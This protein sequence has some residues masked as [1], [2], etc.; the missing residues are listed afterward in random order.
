[1]VYWQQF[2]RYT[3]QLDMSFRDYLKKLDESGRLLHVTT[4]I[5]KTYEIAGVLKKAEPEPVIFEKVKE[6]DFR[7]VGNLFGSKASFA[8][9]FGIPVSKI[10]S[11]LTEAISHPSPCQIVSE[12]PCQE[13]VQTEPD[14]DLLPI[15]RHCDQD[16]GNYISSGVMIARHP[17]YGQNL[18]FHRCM[19]VSKTE[20]AVR[21]VRSRHFDA[22]LQ[23]QKKIDVAICI[24]N[25]PNVMAAAATSIEIGVDELE[26]ANTLEPVQVVKA[27]TVDV[28]VPAETEFVLEGTVYLDKKHAEGPFVDLTETYDVIRLEPVLEIKAITHRKDALW[29]ALLPGALEHKLLMGMPREPTIFKKVNEVVN[30]LDVN[31]DPGGA[32][33]LHAIVQ[34]DKQ[35]EDDGLKAIRAAFSGHRSC[36]H[37]FVVDKDIDIYNPQEVEWAMATRFQADRG[38]IILDKEQGSSLD[39]SS[40]AGTYQTTKVG[41]DLTKPLVTAGKSFEKA[42]FPD[43]DLSRFIQE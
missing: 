15:L 16:G 13:V 22:Y 40:E 27:H 35:N 30:C 41:F 19:Q 10:I 4:P 5:S 9:Y 20:L 33:W 34:I 18:D 2:S 12:A 42:P 37:V 14:L 17:V 11:T 25:P 23:D 1:M 21:V 24:G 32:S 3:D 6:S 43:I 29:Q 36:K 31:V 26:I 8:S 7:V 39:P 38:L 28:Y